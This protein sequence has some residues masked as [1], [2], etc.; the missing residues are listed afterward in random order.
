[1]TGTLGHAAIVV[2]LGLS[3]FAGVGFEV[4]ACLGGGPHGRSAPIPEAP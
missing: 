3:L 2:A 1:V 4:A